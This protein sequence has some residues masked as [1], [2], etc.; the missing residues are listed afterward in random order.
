MKIFLKKLW[1]NCCGNAFFNMRQNKLLSLCILVAAS[2]FA[3]RLMADY[4]IMSQRY[5]ADRTSLVTKD[6]VN[7]YCSD[8]ESPVE[9]GYGVPAV[10]CVSSSDMKN[11]TDHGSVF[12]AEKATPWAERT[13]APTVIERDGK[14][15]LCFG[16]GGAN[17]GVT[18]APTPD[19]QGPD[20]LRHTLGAASSNYVALRSGSVYY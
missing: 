7:I 4:P 16:N 6:R 12:R 18:T 13:W 11:W 8:D 20:Q 9:G 3:P 15:F 1:V 17:I 19:R 10:V 5:L 2:T 14:F